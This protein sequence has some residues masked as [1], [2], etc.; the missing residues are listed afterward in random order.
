MKHD[1]YSLDRLIN[2][3]LKDLNFYTS[4]QCWYLK[5]FVI[6]NRDILC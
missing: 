1:F 3:F 2:H 4:L 6:F 5:A